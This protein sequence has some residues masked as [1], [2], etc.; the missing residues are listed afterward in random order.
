MTLNHVRSGEGPPLLLLHSL[1]GSI[2]MWEPVMDRLAAERDVIAVDLPGFGDSPPLPQGVEPSAAN[3]AAAAIDFFDTLG[4]DGNPAVAG[5]S[6]G[7]WVAFE[8][9]RARRATAAVG[10]CSAGFWGRPLEPHGG[11]LTEARRRGRL[12]VPLLPLILFSRWGRRR[13]LANAMHRPERLTREQ[14]VR[15]VGGYLRSPAYPEASRLMRGNVVAPLDGITAPLTLAWGEYDR[16]VRRPPP[17]RVPESVHQL[18][19]AGCGHVPTWDDP[20]LVARV[21]LAAVATDDGTRG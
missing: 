18:E 7:G 16:L 8:C 13:A 15:L 2:V 21:I 19:L 14:A 9:A 5:I 12:L 6:L 17:D 3:L 10:L 11:W 20:E 4:V 1:G